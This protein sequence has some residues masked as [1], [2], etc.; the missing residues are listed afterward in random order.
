MK[1]YLLNRETDTNP[2]NDHEVHS[3]DC[4]LLPMT[5][6]INLGHHPNCQHA[7]IEAR[8]HFSNVDG[9]K[10]CVPDCHRG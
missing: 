3:E 6:Y 8:K 1:R 2:N 4:R 9:C 10:V 7:M 5:N